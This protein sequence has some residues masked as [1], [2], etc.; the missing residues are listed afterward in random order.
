MSN[1]IF[2]ELYK[3]YEYSFPEFSVYLYKFFK[4]FELEYSDVDKLIEDDDLFLS[5]VISI[6]SSKDADLIKAE[7]KLNGVTY[8]ALYSNI[9]NVQ[10][11]DLYLPIPQLTKVKRIHLL[12]GDISTL[13]K[14]IIDL[15]T[16][17]SNVTSYDFSN[18]DLYIFSSPIKL[19][20]KSYIKAIIIES[21]N[22]ITFI[23][24]NDIKREEKSKK[25][26]KRKKKRTRKRKKK[27]KIR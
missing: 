1:K 14:P 23:T 7:I 26:M 6:C 24:I 18:E 12:H 9:K 4:N 25:A 8:N 17:N 20:N 13:D 2:I 21:Q 5:W 16:Q 19:I 11:Y 10:N 22:H 27:S 15:N 3:L